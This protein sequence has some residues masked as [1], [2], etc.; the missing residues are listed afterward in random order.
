M[1]KCWLEEMFRESL[2][3]E[4]GPGIYKRACSAKQH[5]PAWVKSS[6]VSPLQSFLE[7]LLWDTTQYSAEPTGGFFFFSRIQSIHRYLVTNLH[8]CQTEWGLS[9]CR[10][11]DSQEKLGSINQQMNPINTY[12]WL[13]HLWHQWYFSLAYFWIFLLNNKLK[14]NLTQITSVCNYY[15]LLSQWLPPRQ[16]W[17]SCFRVTAEFSSVEPP[18]WQVQIPKSTFT[19]PSL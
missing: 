4:D 9:T 17:G 7:C 12:M 16:K 5:Q 19:K 13:F 2:C 6:G 10:F 11:V 8:A 14:N 15:F 18:L 1:G 3:K